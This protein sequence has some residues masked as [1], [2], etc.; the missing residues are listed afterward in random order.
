MT[1]PSRSRVMSRY[2]NATITAEGDPL[3]VLFVE[4]PKLAEVPGLA[5]RSV[6]DLHALVQVSGPDFE[7]L[8]EI[9]ASLRG[10][11]SVEKARWLGVAWPQ[12][13]PEQ[14]IKPEPGTK[15]LALAL[16]LAMGG[17]T[18]GRLA[19]GTQISV[20]AGTSMEDAVLPDGRP[21]RSVMQISQTL[22][23]TAMLRVNR[24]RTVEVEVGLERAEV[25][26]VVKSIPLPAG[27][28]VTVTEVRPSP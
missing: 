4:E 13:G 12:L 25:E 14:V 5:L 20:H 26:R 6:D 24:Q 7:R 19:D 1:L 11:L 27:Y 16:R 15:G 28:S 2:P 17:V 9:V 8:T 22:A 10:A 23:P 18:T 3:T 21:V